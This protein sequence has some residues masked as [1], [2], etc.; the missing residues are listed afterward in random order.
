MAAMLQPMYWGKTEYRGTPMQHH[1]VTF[2]PDRVGVRSSHHTMV[3]VLSKDTHIIECADDLKVLTTKRLAALYE[4]LATPG[5]NAAGTHGVNVS[6][7]PDIVWNALCHIRHYGGDSAEVP[8]PQAEPPKRAGEPAVA[9]TAVSAAMP[10]GIHH[11][12]APAT[13]PVP[14]SA[15]KSPQPPSSKGEKTRAIGV[16]LLRP[17][18]CTTADI[19]ALTGWPSVSV[20]AMAKAC[21]LNL[22][23]EKIGGA[24]RYFGNKI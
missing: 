10:R 19:L 12:P 18:G 22:R 14:P 23:K 4:H 5:G 17:E 11:A 3:A 7:T 20:P 9:A 2:Y 15:P 1:E 13:Q 21:S 24:T 16:L 8:T 6:I